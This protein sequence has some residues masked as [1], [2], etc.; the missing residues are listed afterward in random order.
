MTSYTLQHPRC[1]FFFTR[2][3]DV[4]RYIHLKVSRIPY[5]TCKA[6]F[7]SLFKTRAYILITAQLDNRVVISS[8]PTSQ[9]QSD[10]LPSSTSMADAQFENEAIRQEKIKGETTKQTVSPVKSF[11]SGGFGGMSAV[12]VGQSTLAR[13]LY[14][15]TLKRD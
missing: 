13:R 10:K 6:C 15:S 14:W 5:N 3:T 12:L 7:E 9:T 4:V 2:S 11:L 1:L 8:Y